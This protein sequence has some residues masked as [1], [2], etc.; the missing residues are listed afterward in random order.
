MFIEKRTITPPEQKRIAGIASFFLIV[1]FV[2]F[3]LSFWSIQI[4]KGKDYAIKAQK[5]IHDKLVLKAPRGIISDRN[6]VVIA[7]N[8]L[9]FSLFF[10][11]SFQDQLQSISKEHLTNIGINDRELKTRLSFYSGKNSRELIPIRRNLPLE[12]VVYLEARPELLS[13]FQIEIEPARAY[14]FG[15][16]GSHVLGFMN[17]ISSSE[18]DLLKDSGYSMGD[19]IGKTGLEKQYENF[20]RGNKGRQSVI[21]DNLGNIHGVTEVVYPTIGATVTTTLDFQLQEQIEQIFSS[22]IGVVAV[23]DLQHGGIVS[24]VSQPNF[25]PEILSGIITSDFWEATLSDPSRPLQNR[26]SQGLYSP[27]SVFKLAVALAGI[28][29]NIISPESMVFCSGSV[30]I[31][32][33]PFRCWQP[34]GHGYVNLADAIKGS[35]NVYFYQLGRK[36]DVDQIAHYALQLG[37]GQPT[38]IDLPNEKQGI[39]PTK[40]WKER[41]KNQAWFPGETIS[42]SIGGGWV[43]VTPAQVLKMISIIALRGH[44]PNIHLVSSIE[45]NGKLVYEHKSVRKKTSIT[46]AHYED[47]I[48]GMWRAVNKEGTARRT[49][50][51][52]L[53]IC[54]KTGTQQILSK[55]NPNYA[56]LV[57]QKRFKPHAWF[58]SFAP[59]NKPEYAMV[60]LVENGGDAGQIA[61]PIAEKVYR[62]LHFKEKNG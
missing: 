4:L 5:N 50:I 25:D 3:I 6:G 40:S 55:E 27:G 51:T 19:V 11:Q 62:L 39:I 58:A 47:I 7:S 26:F 2:F 48:E 54:G 17:E 14:P 18:L 1:V 52:D 32:D 42:V 8:R 38:G 56:Q 60:I 46:P 15:K 57:L 61:V 29:E 10:R 28:S 36:L 30:Q 23:I 43:S 59:R 12:S 53:D 31:Y 37:L 33:R 20:L 13:A 9:H 16:S 35:C 21:K 24:L 49:A 34:G 41:E 44:I 22:H 45:K